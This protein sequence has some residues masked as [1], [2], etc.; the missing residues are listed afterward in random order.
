MPR[1]AA[2][3][4]CVDAFEHEYGY[5]RVSVTGSI[6]FTAKCLQTPGS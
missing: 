5:I 3:A 1:W 2:A 6:A 4:A